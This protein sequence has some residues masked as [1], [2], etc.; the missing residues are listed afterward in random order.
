MSRHY[1]GA[2]AEYRQAIDDRAIDFIR[3]AVL[4][5]G[6]PP[7]IREL[8]EHLG[9]KSTQ[10]GHKVLVR[11]QAAGRIIRQPGSPRSITIVEDRAS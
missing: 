6:Y 8:C 7:S 9:L 11:L 2:L 10:S 1:T 4:A 3:A 5:R